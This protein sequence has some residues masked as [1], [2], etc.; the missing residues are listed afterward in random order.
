MILVT[1]ATGQLGKIVVQNLV[2]KTSA[3]RIAAFVRD[4]SKAA[5]LTSEGVDVR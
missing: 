3:S 2:K 4:A 1:G 5:D